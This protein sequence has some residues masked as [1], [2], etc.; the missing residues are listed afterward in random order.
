MGDSRVSL[1]VKEPDNNISIQKIAEEH[2]EYIRQ[3]VVDALL[4]EDVRQCVTRSERMTN[5]EL[6]SELDIY[7]NTSF[8]WIKITHF[9][10][11]GYLWIPVIESAFMQE[12][13]VAGFP[14]I[15]QKSNH[16]NELST[17]EDIISC[18]SIGLS[19]SAKS[20]FDAFSEECQIAI[21]HRWFSE[22]ERE[23]WFQELRKLHS[24]QVSTPVINW[25]TTLLHYDRIG[26][27][28][29]H[30]FYPTARA[31]LGFDIKSLSIY[32]PEFQKDFH[33]Q[34]LAVPLI[35]YY[36]SKNNEH[37]LPSLWPTFEDVGLPASM[38]DSHA[39]IPVHP[40]VW[41]NDLSGFLVE[42]EQL[43][44]IRAPRPYLRVV[45][46]LSVR[47]VVMLDMPEWHLKLPLTIRTLG[48][49]NIRT[50]K[51]STIL[52]GDI[53]QTLLEKIVANEPSITNRVLLTRED[54]GGHVDNRAYLG[55]ILRHYP[56]EKL[57]KSTLIPVAALMAQT[58]TGNTV[59]E[60]V[61]E[62]FY[63][64]N[65]EAFL[66]DY[67]DLTLRLHL[68]LWLR[69]GI[70]LESN[71][72]NSVI[73]LNREEPRL[74]ILLKD[75]DSARIH[76][77]YLVNRWPCFASWITQLQ[78]RRILVADELPLAQMFTTITLQLNI[79]V[80]VERYAIIL[81]LSVATLYLRIRD[82]IKIILSEFETAGEN[83]Q[84]ANQLL[85]EDDQLYIKYLLIAATLAEKTETGAVDVNKFYGYSAPNFLKTV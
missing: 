14:L 71:Q 37:R 74:R 10:E 59:A 36:P 17:I 84:L 50:I 23:R 20:A 55:F 42:A 39:L 38:A 63:D 68:L 41:K 77:N 32:G 54:C 18:F 69:Y 49:K 5:I 30:P 52:D 79:A 24:L 76:L 46:T 60:E 56:V 1:F 72:Q 8:D 53:I 57:N 27:F 44:V 81:G 78:D 66:S 48:A 45:P 33:L 19:L 28:L 2:S 70:A 61:A 64:N 47:T 15:W 31:K 82:Q 58:S 4:R 21:E 9:D 85:L 43:E 65:L 11:S 16:L 51:P 3:R 26:A 13:R 67:F 75:N 22:L 12:L 34:W 40:F 29:D 25:H 7:A 35:H 62:N 73:V 6:P 80:L 83:I